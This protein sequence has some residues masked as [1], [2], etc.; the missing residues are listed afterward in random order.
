M[1]ALLLEKNY[2]HADFPADFP[3]FSYKNRTGIVSYI[4]CMHY[5]FA[6]L[7]INCVALLQFCAVNC[8]SEISPEFFLHGISASKITCM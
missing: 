8:A 7:A 4:L 6:D 3:A 5:F 1:L 2:T